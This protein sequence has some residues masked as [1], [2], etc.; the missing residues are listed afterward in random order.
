MTYLNNLE[1]KHHRLCTEQ[2]ENNNRTF[3]LLLEFEDKYK[4]HNEFVYYSIF[5]FKAYHSS[6]YYNFILS[7]G[8]K[9]NLKKI[10]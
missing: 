2:I 1:N 10:K 4:L 9:I 6:E 3:W 8:R 5:N 7:K